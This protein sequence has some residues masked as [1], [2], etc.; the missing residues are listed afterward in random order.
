MDDKII[1]IDDKIHCICR[2]IIDDNVIVDK[3]YCVCGIIDD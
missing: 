3:N 1:M 2:I